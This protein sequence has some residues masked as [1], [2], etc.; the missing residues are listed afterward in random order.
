MFRVQLMISQICFG[1]LDIIMGNIIGLL[2]G[3]NLNIKTNTN[4]HNTQFSL[5]VGILWRNII[6]PNIIQVNGKALLEISPH[7]YLRTKKTKTLK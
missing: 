3:K 4:S 7:Q 2:Y 1:L 6:M 5:N